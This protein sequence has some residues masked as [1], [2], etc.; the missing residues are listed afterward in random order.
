[1]RHFGM[2]SWREAMADLHGTG[3]LLRFDVAGLKEA[4]STWAGAL[5]S[6]WAA[7]Y[8]LPVFL[9]LNMVEAGTPFIFGN[10]RLLAAEMISYVLQWTVLPLGLYY[11]C[12]MWRLDARYPRLIVC[13]NWLAVWQSLL[14]A[15]LAIAVAFGLIPENLAPIMMTLAVLYLLAVE[16]FTAQHALGIGIMG[17]VGV[18][19]LDLFIAW[20]IALMRFTILGAS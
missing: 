20:Q 10:L 1:M 12:Q 18:V 3:R 19:L 7:L 6:F 5:H 11:L 17:A 13:L 14:Y 2:P 4:E 8:A 15:V 9:L 16:G